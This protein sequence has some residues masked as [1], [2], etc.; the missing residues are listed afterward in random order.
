M[1]LPYIQICIN[2]LAAQTFPHNAAQCIAN[3]GHYFPTMNLA[4]ENGENSLFT[5][6]IVIKLFLVIQGI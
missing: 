5:Y 2:I 6:L 1:I 4:F 3:G